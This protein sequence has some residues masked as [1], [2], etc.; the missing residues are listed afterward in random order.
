MRQSTAPSTAAVPMVA[1]AVCATVLT[2][3]TPAALTQRFV[4]SFILYSFHSGAGR[5][6]P[7][8]SISPRPARP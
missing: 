3:R 4:F 1:T 6:A 5:M 2:A 7:P 8:R